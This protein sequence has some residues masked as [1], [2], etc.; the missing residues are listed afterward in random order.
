MTINGA[1]TRSC[2]DKVGPPVFNSIAVIGG[3]AWGTALAVTAQRAGRRTTLWARE[4]AVVEAIAQTRRNP[5]LPSVALPA[6]LSIRNDVAAAVDGADLVVLVPPSQHL[7]TV[8]RQVEAL[9]PPGVPVVICSKGIELDSGLLMSHVVAAEMPGRPQAVLSGPTFA[10]EVAA[11]LPTAVTIAAPLD[12]S[13]FDDAHLA[14]RVAVSFATPTFRPYV[15]DDVI[16]VEIGGAVKNVIAIACGIAAG[17]RLG[18]NA[19]AALITRGLAEITRLGAAIGARADTLCGLAGAGDLM[20]TCS[21]ELSRNFSYGKALGEGCRPSMSDDGPV[22]EGAVNARAVTA[23]AIEL[24]IDMPICRAVDAVLRG[25]TPNEAINSLMTSDLRAE[26]PALEDGPR[27]VNPV[28]RV[29]EKER[30]F[31]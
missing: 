29:R 28:R 25:D 21:S 30:M 2:N 20:L 12:R 27:I 15:S 8:A 24:G 5:F 9:L 16:G 4:A 17:R 22:V 18:A 23:L 14:A 7:R 1:A 26:P 19:R 6:D 10:T 3:G 13:T 11:G 31:S